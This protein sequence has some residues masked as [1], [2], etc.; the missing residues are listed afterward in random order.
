MDLQSFLSHFQSVTGAGTTY[1]AKCPAHEDKQSSLSIALGRD[2]GIV[3][4]CHAGCATEAILD[5]IGV[6]MRELMPPEKSGRN[7][8]RGGAK[9]AA[10]VPAAKLTPV[11]PDQHLVPGGTYHNKKTNAQETISCVYE[12]RDADGAVRVRVARTPEKSFPVCH[13]GADGQW[14]WGRGPYGNLLYRLP[15]LI[16][17]V[18]AGR[19]VYVVEGEKDVESLAAMGYDATC[20]LGGGGKGKWPDGVEGYFSGGD[21]AVIPDNDGPGRT[22]AEEVCEALSRTAKEVRIVDLA[23]GPV[24]LPSKGDATDFFRLVGKKSAAKKAFDELV[25]QAE[26]WTG[27]AKATAPE[28]VGEP[29]SE[30]GVLFERVSGYCVKNGCLCQETQDGETMLCSFA[31]APVEEITKDD[32]VNAELWFRIRGW[33]RS[34][35]LLPELELS[36][37]EYT[38]MNWPIRRWGA[39]GNI[40]PGTTTKGKVLWAMTESS[41]LNA[42]RR[43]EYA[44]SGWR[45]IDGKWAYLYQGGAIGADNVSVALPNMERYGLSGAPDMAVGDALALVQAMLVAIPERI[46]VPILGLVYLTPLCEFLWQRGIMPKFALYVLGRTGSGKSTVSAIAL[47][48][49]GRFTLDAFP[50]SFNDT[51]NAIRDS[52]FVLKDCLLVVDDYHPPANQ[53]EKRRMEEAAQAIARG[54]G[55]RQGRNRL[56][57][58][59]KKNAATPPR[60]MVMVTG[61]DLPAIGES[62]IARFYVVPVSRGDIPLD[63]VLSTLTM[64]A[65]Q[66]T[67]QRAM[68]GYIEWLIRRSDG[69]ADEL[70]RK[71]YDFREAM[72][73][74]LPGAHGRVVEAAAHLMLGYE[75]MLLF[76]LDTGFIDR[77]EFRRM[78]IDA[79]L[80]LA[81][82]STEQVRDALD[83]KPATVFVRTMQQLLATKAYGVKDLRDATGGPPDNMIGYADADYYYLTPDIAYAAVSKTCQIKGTLF[84]A[85]QKMLYKYLKEEHLIVPQED[86]NATRA[87]RADGRQIRCLWFPRKVIDGEPEHRTP[88]PVQTRLNADEVQQDEGD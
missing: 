85:T 82:N 22:H 59:L 48:H 26:P 62:G 29:V 38:A 58:D 77:D 16:A 13:A 70:E 83:E 1:M 35:A 3:L 67:L 21:V 74:S 20:N 31:A 41:R 47:S 23:K 80:A 39:N 28:E 84:Q 73:D 4:H 2:G 5:R 81:A 14:Y 87:I 12:Y 15:E 44:H 57:K 36:G 7:P 32:G 56:S 79:R 9:S 19:R 54:V 11:R 46:I 51:A 37:E 69:L 8:A 65:A 71:F 64:E 88:E 30:A 24:K 49:F 86:G 18:K 17:A 50:S 76:W 66:G 52:M 63:N 40:K 55:D 68:A 45:K 25:G 43:T 33:A 75:M 42:A 27:G 6:E 10:P 61:E 53:I 78:M 72:G 60:G 34:G